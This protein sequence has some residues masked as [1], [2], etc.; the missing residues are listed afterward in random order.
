MLNKEI[1]KNKLKEIEFLVL[2]SDG[3]CVARGTEIKETI[4]DNYY[5]YIMK[6]HTLSD[7]LAAKIRQTTKHLPVFIS[8]GRSQQYLETVY[9]KVKDCVAFIP[10]NGAIRRP[11]SLDEIKREIIK[12]E[13]PVAF[14]PK[15]FILTVH[16]P[17]EIRQIYQIVRETDKN[18][19]VMWN[20]EAFDI[21]DKNFSKGKVFSMAAQSHKFM[22]IG[23]RV[24]DME[25]L[26]AAYL[27]V[28]AD[29]DALEA[30][31]WTIGGN[32]PGEQLID[33]LLKYYEG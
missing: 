5:I 28:S 20:G 11:D 16:A 8:S 24:N 33:Y 7:S 2:D 32:L 10:E 29:I 30:P 22:A 26:E 12:R 1:P 25:L 18:L 6:T 23:D 4:Q 14:E 17:T 15:N 21:Q 13:L 9:S 19:K 27:P 31:Y 3:V